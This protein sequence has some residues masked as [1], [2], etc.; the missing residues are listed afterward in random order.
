MINN[1]VFSTFQWIP[2]AGWCL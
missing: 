1:F 2:G